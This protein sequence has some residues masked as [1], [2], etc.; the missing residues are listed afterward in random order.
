MSELVKRIFDYGSISTELSLLSDSRL[1]ELLSKASPLGSGIGGRS[2]SVVI[3]EKPVFVKKIRLTELERRH[4]FSTENV[5]MLPS[6]YQYGIGSTGFGAWRELATHIMTTNW[7]LTG[8]CQNFPLMYHWR[9]LPEPKTQIMIPEELK[10]TEDSVRYWE[11]SIQIHERLQSIQ[12]SSYSIALFLENIPET[13]NERLKRQLNLGDESFSTSCA[14][15]ENDLTAVSKFIGSKGLIHFDAHFFNLLTD[16]SRV[17]FSDFGLAMS[18][19]F[20]LSNEEIEF[21]RKHRDYDRFYTVTHLVNWLIT[22]ISGRDEIE[23]A[24]QG[25]AAGSPQ[26][27]FPSSIEA[28]L[29]KYHPIAL[30]MNRFFGELQTRSR[31]TPFPTDELAKLEHLL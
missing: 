26:K 9:I 10:E 24:L 21:F 18:D 12:E 8:E 29:Q 28:I 25:Y 19:R 3:S 5:F 13:L 23:P 16:G 1:I 2:L 7:V 22:A 27:F 14:L 30:V 31:K 15:V 6:Y 11:N 17:Y 20:R 4:A